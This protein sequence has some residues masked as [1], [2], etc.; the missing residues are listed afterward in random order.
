MMSKLLVRIHSKINKQFS[1]DI[2]LAIVIG[3]LFLLLIGLVISYSRL[4]FDEGYNLQV[5]LNLIQFGTYASRTLYGFTKFD[6]F[7]STGPLSLFAVMASFAI[8]DVGVLQA[9]FVSV[10]FATLMLISVYGLSSWLN[11]R[12]IGAVSLLLM[13]TVQESWYRLGTVVGDGA[14]IALILIGLLAWS[15]YEKKRQWQFAIVSGVLWGGAVWAKPSMIMAV[16]F[17]I[18]T[19]V[20]VVVIDKQQKFYSVRVFGWTAIVTMTLGISWFL[21]SILETGLASSLVGGNAVGL[22][23]EQFSFRWGH[24]LGHNLPLLFN[25]IAFGTIVGVIINLFT[26]VRLRNFSI[27][28]LI[29]NILPLAWIVWWILF[30]DGS[31]YRHLFPGLIFGVVPLSETLDTLANHWHRVPIVKVIVIV[32]LFFG[33]GPALKST[34]QYV[35][36]LE[37]SQDDKYAQEQFAVYVAKLDPN[38]EIMGW[39][40]FMAWDIAFLSNRTFGDIRSESVVNPLK[41]VYLIITPTISSSKNARVSV[42]SIIERCSDNMVYDHD[43]YQLYHLK[44]SCLIDPD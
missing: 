2:V 34:I 28:R 17:I 18:I 40:W 41:N 22:I 3:L 14:G 1:V 26:C 43:G 30:N 37:K 10:I 35:T 12:K 38:S 42:S 15:F 25:T 13:F 11:G 32:I 6:P 27:P 44:A 7:I 24:N 31:F 29:T 19:L 20:A 33:A 16:L 8:F 5:P 21:I 4:N 36:Q 23:H 39:G 9:R